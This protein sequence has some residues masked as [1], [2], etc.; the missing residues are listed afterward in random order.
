V[1]KD[2][3]IFEKRLN[4]ILSARAEA[5]KILEQVE[6]YLQVIMALPE[7]APDIALTGQSS[8]EEREGQVPVS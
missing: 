5:Q 2:K 7:A 4:E 3:Q 6:N 8:L 1:I